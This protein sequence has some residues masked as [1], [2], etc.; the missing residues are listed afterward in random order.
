MKF[1]VI[2]ASH[3]SSDLSYGLL[4]IPCPV[5]VQG[6]RQ[7]INLNPEDP[8]YQPSGVR[9]LL[10]TERIILERRAE[11]T[12]ACTVVIHPQGH[13]SWQDLSTLIADLEGEGF[14]VTL[15]GEVA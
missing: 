6:G 2:F 13:G 15:V 8:H 4:F 5:W 3:E 7:I 14:R 9:R 12:R 11:G 10:T 1:T